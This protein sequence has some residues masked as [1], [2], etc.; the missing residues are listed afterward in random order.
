MSAPVVDLHALTLRLANALHAR[1][2]SRLSV[3]EQCRQL[4]IRTKDE[5]LV[6]FQW[7]AAQRAYWSMRPKSGK[8]LLLKPRQEGFTTLEIADSYLTLKNRPGAQ[9]VFLA[10]EKTKAERIFAIAR[11][12]FRTDPH[13]PELDS[14]PTKSAMVKSDD[15]WLFVGTAGSDTFGR[16]LTLSKVH[17]SEVSRWPGSYDDIQDLVV[18]L[19]EAARYG[20]V[21]METTAN[22]IDKW[23]HPTWQ[24]PR[25]WIRVFIPWYCNPE[26]RVRKLTQADTDNI[27]DT[28]TDE[29]KALIERHRLDAAQIAWR[30][31]NIYSLGAK[32]AEEYPESPATAFLV[33]GQTL[34]NGLRVSL[35]IQACAPPISSTHRPGYDEEVFVR[36]PR[37]GMRYFIGA[38][39]ADGV[40]GGDACAY[41]VRD[42]WGGL[43]KVVR[44]MSEPMEFAYVLAAEGHRWNNATIA[45]ETNNMGRSTL[46]TLHKVIMYPNIWQAVQ[47]TGREHILSGKLGWQTTPGTKPTLLANYKEDFENG[48]WIVGS[49]LILEDMAAVTRRGSV[50]DTNGKDVFMADAVTKEVLRLDLL[51]RGDEPAPTR[52][53]NPAFGSIKRRSR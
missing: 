35:A 27:L 8:V 11:R 18:G 44:V 7:N 19:S 29:E 21:I 36:E 47:W 28:L 37:P 45:P 25:D 32:F 43:C 26:H 9:Q 3:E 13:P 16:G 52:F 49:R 5:R 30:R 15:S 46:D 24:E 39:V 34:F 6:K 41:T 20:L 42:E 17:G 10:D 31:Q 51:K 23:F 50:Y 22:G 14:P 1:A 33:S 38:D 2:S 40:E 12:F 53:R 4:T 48:T